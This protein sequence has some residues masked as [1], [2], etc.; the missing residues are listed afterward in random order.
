MTVAITSGSSRCITL[1]RPTV[2]INA[3]DPLQVDLPSTGAI[4]VQAADASPVQ[5]VVLSALLALVGILQLLPR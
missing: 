2:T 3:D 1:I 4:S 5:V